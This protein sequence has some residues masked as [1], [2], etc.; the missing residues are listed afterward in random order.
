M[1]TVFRRAGFFAALVV[2][3][4]AFGTIGFV[5]IEAY[6]WFDALYMTVITL[7]TVGYYEVRALSTAGR[8]FNMVLLLVGVNLIL[9]GIGMMTSTIFE[10]QL[11]NYFSRRRSKRMI[12]SL[13]SHFI[14]CGY[15]RVGRGAAQELLR[16]KVP[17]VIVDANE[18]KVEE[19][20]KA[21]MLAVLADCTR[22]ETLRGVQIDRATG[23]IAALATDADN[24]FLTLSAKTLNPN[25]VVAARANEEEADAKLRRAGANSVFSPYGFT[26]SRL[27]QSILRPHVTQFLDYA[28]LDPAND[29]SIEQLRVEEDSEFSRR[30]LR[31][32]PSLRKEYGVSVLAVRRGSGEM[33][34]NPGPELIIGTGDHLI[35][36]GKSESLKRVEDIVFAKRK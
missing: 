17:F 5:V 1:N 27:A 36:M 26:G 16:N 32:L 8:A 22:D 4:I 15:G 11:D 10:L 21:G 19:I 2:G 25:L 31:D 23:L 3:L 20:M 14:I 34:F 13:S 18:D 29:W 7:T 33:I 12:N 30:S 9:L 6:P 35:V 28:T 24:L